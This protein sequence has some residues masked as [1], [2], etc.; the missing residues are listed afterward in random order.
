M[1]T[2]ASRITD[3]RVTGLTLAEIGER[4]GLAASSVSDIEQQRTSEPKGGA[5]LKLVSLHESL[6]SKASP[7]A[8][9]RKAG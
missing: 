2:W 3:L 4:I 9:R 8:T 1:T 7:R 5:A 6:C